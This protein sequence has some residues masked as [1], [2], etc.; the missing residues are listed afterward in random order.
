MCQISVHNWTR[1]AQLEVSKNLLPFNKHISDS[2]EACLH[3]LYHGRTQKWEENTVPFLN[4]TLLQLS[5]FSHEKKGKWNI[6][7]KEKE[8]LKWWSLSSW[9][10]GSG[11][12]IRQ[13]KKETS[14]QQLTLHT[15]TQKLVLYF[16]Y[17]IYL[18]IY[19]F[20]RH[21]LQFCDSKWLKLSVERE[22]NL[23]LFTA[24]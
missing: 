24:P 1:K 9:P 6:L 2:Q 20:L 5:S 8:K 17:F 22:N 15:K 23:V 3:L 13:Q 4:V 19:L 18:F 11:E 10:P 7:G 21:L 14:K 12:N 16:F